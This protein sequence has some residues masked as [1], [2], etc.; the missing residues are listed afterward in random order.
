MLFRSDAAKRLLGL[1]T[2]THTPGLPDGPGRNARGTRNWSGGWTWVGEEGPELLNLPRGSEI[3][4]NA[5]SMSFLGSLAAMAP[6]FGG[7]V[8]TGPLVQIDKVI[9]PN[10]AVGQAFANQIGDVLSRSTSYRT[11]SH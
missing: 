11:R 4:S 8:Q 5:D 3:L 6:G 2:D 1:P 9:V 7:M 10:M